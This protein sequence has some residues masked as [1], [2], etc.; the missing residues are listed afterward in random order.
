M[1]NVLLLGTEL[2]E[3]VIQDRCDKST[4]PDSCHHEAGDRF[5]GRRGQVNGFGSAINEF[6]EGGYL[7]WRM[8]L[9][10]KMRLGEG[11]W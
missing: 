1:V 3:V 11:A 10:A 5:N 2:H 8:N 6:G 4:C 7:L 9:I